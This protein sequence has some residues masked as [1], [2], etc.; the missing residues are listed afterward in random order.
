M[1]KPAAPQREHPPGALDGHPP[2]A[3]GSA[4]V[5][6][7]AAHNAAHN[8]SHNGTEPAGQ[9]T[10]RPGWPLSRRRTLRLVASTLLLVLLGTASGLVGSWL[11]PETFAARAD[12]VYSLTGEEAGGSQRVDPALQTQI[13]LLE[14]RAVLAPVARENGQPFDDFADTVTVE[15]L[16]NSE[17]IQVEVR[18][19]DRQAALRSLRSILA[20]YDE[21]SRSNQQSRVGDYLKTELTQ[22]QQRI[23][24]IEAHQADAEDP[25][26]TDQQLQSLQARERDI[27]SRLNEN[28]ITKLSAPQGK[29]TSKPY[30]LDDPV[31]P[32]PVFA[33]V[34]GGFAGLLIALGMC[35]IIARRWTKS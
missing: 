13:V 34:T 5:S 22:V 1:T 33:A 12:L 23:S 25:T 8:A 18:D 14:S 15:L 30:L 28:T 2:A 29:L 17:V 20:R 10:G 24:D 19:Q 7:D 26:T 11:W 4:V 6:R 27:L 35:G 32:K 9:T 16:S 31:S 21:L 3:T